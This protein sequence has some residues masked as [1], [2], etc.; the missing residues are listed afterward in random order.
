MTADTPVG[1][2]PQRENI[3][4]IVEILGQHDEIVRG[5]RPLEQVALEWL[6]AGFDDAEEIDA[7]IEARCLAAGD[8]QALERAGLT[9]E[10]AAL[11]TGAG[12]GGYEDTVGFKLIKGD[13][14][15]DEARRIITSEFWN[16]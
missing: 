8:A 1:P 3:R 12:A 10:Q 5:G 13:L 9:P 16:S 6:A 2:Q 4:A 11:R 7:W 15:F 14:S